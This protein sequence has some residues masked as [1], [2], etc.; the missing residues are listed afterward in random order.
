LGGGL[1]APGESGGRGA[2]GLGEKGTNHYERVQKKKRQKK[3]ADE[4]VRRERRMEK[5]KGGNRLM[6]NSKKKKP[7]L[8]VNNPGG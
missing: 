1:P 6:A 3:I 4:K 7:T 5:Q 8:R 2:K